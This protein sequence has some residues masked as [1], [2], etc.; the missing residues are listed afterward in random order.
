MQICQCQRTILI[1]QLICLQQM[2]D[3]YVIV[4]EAELGK[5][6]QRVISSDSFTYRNNYNILLTTKIY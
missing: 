4:F 5:K 6:P 2:V 3:E 1:Q